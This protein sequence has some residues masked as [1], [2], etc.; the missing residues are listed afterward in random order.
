MDHLDRT[1][2][3]LKKVAAHLS[4]YLF[5]KGGG[6]AYIFIWQAGKTPDTLQ[7]TE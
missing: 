6:G 1:D 3:L 5:R 7:G 2:K 4:V